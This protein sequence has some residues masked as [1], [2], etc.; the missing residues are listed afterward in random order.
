M[1]DGEATTTTIE[2]VP[3]VAPVTRLIDLDRVRDYAVAARDPNPL[4]TDTEFAAKTDFG[5]PVAHGMLVLAL[6]SEAMTAQFG[7]RWA[8]DGQL[9]VRWRAPAI[10]PVEVTASAEPR[11]L[12]DGRAEYAV[13]CRAAGGTVLLTGTASV[14]LGA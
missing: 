8:S 9:K 6:L 7:S 1:S 14:T 4:H 11:A 10:M 13:Q 12:T 3:A 5:H 2:G